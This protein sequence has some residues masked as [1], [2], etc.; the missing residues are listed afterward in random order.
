MTYNCP[1]LCLCKSGYPSALV[2]MVLRFLRRLCTPLLQ[3]ACLRRLPFVFLARQT[4][5]YRSTKTCPASISC[6]CFDHCTRRCGREGSS[7]F[8]SLLDHSSRKY[9]WND[10]SAYIIHY[11]GRSIVL[12][13]EFTGKRQSVR[14]NLALQITVLYL[15]AVAHVTILY[16]RLELLPFYV[17]TRR[18][19]PEFP[20]LFGHAC[21]VRT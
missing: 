17:R 19:H 14:D 12:S 20:A 13:L 4:L 18:L 2:G 8:I 21:S 10:L 7:P 16:A 1:H 3:Q 6:M 11:F 5:L 15:Y 9:Y